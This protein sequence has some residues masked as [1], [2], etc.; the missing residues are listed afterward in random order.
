M[1]EFEFYHRLA[2]RSGATNDKMRFRWRA[3]LGWA[4]L[5]V[6]AGGTL[7][8]ESTTGP[9]FITADEIRG[10]NDV[11]TIAEGKVEVRRDDS[12]MT[13][14]RVTYRH[15]EDET[16]AVGNVRLV[17]D[18]DV[19]SGPYLRLKS[20]ENVG[21]FEQPEYLF[22]RVPKSTSPLALPRA[23]ET[24]SGHASRI[25]FV[26]EGLYR[27]KSATY[28][29]C[30]PAKR[31][32]YVEADEIDL[33]YNREAG[34]ASSSK[35][36][37][38]D[39]PILYSPW[40]SFSLNHKRRSGLLAPT[41]G[42][43]TTSGL[44]LTL[45]WYWNIAPNMDATI[46]PRIMTKRGL[47]LNSELRYLDYAYNGEAHLEYLPGDQLAH[48]D[49][50]AYSLMHN[51]VLA[52]GLTGNINVNGASD[53]AYFADLSSRVAMVSQANLLRQGSLTYG[54]DWWSATL[55]AQ[56]FQTLQD[57]AAPVAVPYY[58]LP[59]LTVAA[60]R[61][62]LPAGL[63]FNFA[64]EY[65]DFSHPTQVIGQ[66][67]VLYPQVSL[68][69]Q[70][71]AFYV[72]PKLGL[73]MTRYTLERQAA[74]VPDQQN[75]QMPIF[76]VDSG[77]VFERGVDWFGRSLTQTLEPRLYYLKVPN[78][79]Q[80]QIPVFDSG[81]ADFNF[82]QIFSENRYGGSDRIG[83]ANQL[84]AAAVSRLIDPATGV[85]LMRGAVGQRI[86]FGDQQVTLPGEV[87]RTSRKS[88]LLAA[89]SGRVM[90]KVFVDTGWQHSL[91]LDRTERFN[92]SGRYQPE[93][94]KVLNAG[95]R[96]TRDQFR[97]IDVSGQWPVGGGWYGVGRYNYSLKDRRV[98]ESLAGFEYD[99]GCWV[100]RFVLHRLATLTAQT[101]T[102]FFVQLELNGLARI[103]SNPL[104]ML[105]RNVPGYGIINQPTADPVFGAY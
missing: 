55:M 101:S 82:A 73:H 19:M 38:K 64:G 27:L 94:D 4:F 28:S 84:T 100:A 104:E 59:Q 43:S 1:L 46:A 53:Y 83:D 33:D 30:S 93:S 10:R 13:T 50:S 48:R 65:V 34:E 87:P 49:R 29:T 51:H 5:S 70:T 98:I 60:A 14:D 16:E 22:K 44:E 91:D 86:Y 95:Y 80:D 35:I 96:Y 97:Q 69:V 17:R 62:D 63:A 76:S 18:D 32:W 45:P 92:L 74:G 103:G 88:D 90:P 105:K 15:A 71:A 85:E 77:V 3:Y 12:I 54:A 81:V 52:P 31:D 67:T 26:G 75:R 2:V 11:E 6:I 25:D 41:F 40:L 61:P 78:R 102:T 99:A 8:A 23:P 57:P 89:F 37:F 56:R 39:T 58:R 66:R 47:Q 72:T 9:T 7:A 79:N 36:Y 20:K 21:F 68:P 24:G 42:S